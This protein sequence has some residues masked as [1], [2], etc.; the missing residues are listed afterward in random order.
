MEN[1]PELLV[2]TDEMDCKIYCDILKQEGIEFEVKENN[3][4]TAEFGASI[5]DSNIYIAGNELQKAKKVLNLDTEIS[6]ELPRGRKT[7]ALV[8]ILVPLSFALI[9]FIISIIIK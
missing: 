2:S 8:W 4:K 3:V 7:L 6:K 1:M 5:F 9:G